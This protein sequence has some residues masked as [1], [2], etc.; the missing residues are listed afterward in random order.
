MGNKKVKEEYVFDQSDFDKY[1]KYCKN[2]FG[3]PKRNRSSEITYFFLNMVF[4]L[5]FYCGAVPTIINGYFFINNLLNN[6]LDAYTTS[7]FILFSMW[8]IPIQI[9]DLIVIKKN[10]KYLKNIIVKTNEEYIL[11]CLVWLDEIK[12]EYIENKKKEFNKYLKYKKL[13]EKEAK[14]IKYW[15]PSWIYFIIRKMDLMVRYVGQTLNPHSRKRSHY[16]NLYPKYDFMFQL[17]E[18]KDV[19]E[20]DNRE[21]FWI[22]RFGKEN[23][24]NVSKGGSA[25]HHR[26]GFKRK[27][28]IYTG[29][30]QDEIERVEK[31]LEFTKNKKNKIGEIN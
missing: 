8:M 22:D 16:N 15:M 25:V 19:S 31:W 28:I 27:D 30:E 12:S 21:K 26:K 2:V 7:L 13:K 23:L 29:V 24:D 14:I 10:N 5:S 17:I 11:D 18:R 6:N 1:V 9:L 20:I 4:Y 3:A